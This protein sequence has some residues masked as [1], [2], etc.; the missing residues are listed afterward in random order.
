MKKALLIFFAIGCILVHLSLLAAD[1]PAETYKVGILPFKINAAQDL[2]YLQE[3]ILDMLTSRIAWENKILVIDKDLC[4]RAYEKYKGNIKEKNA[5]EI[6]R[7]LGA[8]YLLFGS[9]TIFGNSASLDAK[10]VD[11][12]GEK[13]TVTVYDQSQGMDGIIPKI[14][15]FATSIN[16]SIFGRVQP[17]LA[18]KPSVAQTPPQPQAPQR[19]VS[20]MNPEL[21]VPKEEL[22]RDFSIIEQEK[23]KRTVEGFLDT[24]EAKRGN[25][26]K[27]RNFPFQ[28]TGM[29]IGDVDNDGNNEIVFINEE[30]DL[31][32]YRYLKGA[33]VSVREIKG[34][35]YNQVVSVDVADINENGTE[36]IFISN[37]NK[38][39]VSSFVLEW[40]GKDFATIKDDLDW[41]LRVIKHPLTGP[42]LLGQKKSLDKPF[43]AGI[44]Q[45]V[46]R[47][48][49]YVEVDEV[50][51]ESSVSIYGFTAGDVNGDG[52]DEFVV[53]DEDDRLR[54]LAKGGVQEWKS[55]ENFGGCLTYVPGEKTGEETDW[56]SKVT[57]ENR[58]YLQPRILLCD[59]DKNKTLEVLVIQN[60][61]RVS[62][63]VQRYRHY[64]SGHIYSLSWDGLGLVENW[65]T[66]KISGYLPDFAVAD[67]DNDGENELV[68]PVVT[69]IGFTYLYKSRSAII[70]YD[71]KF[72][73]QESEAET[74]TERFSH[75][76]RRCSSGG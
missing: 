42:I 26:W 22:D 49:K 61:S 18:M 67:I 14:N 5:R 29:D 34:K 43:M 8:D 73:Q 27:S 1:Q 11:L 46:W 54:V 64:G 47:D 44:Y 9:I 36:E 71:L 19:P 31:W 24:G 39:T 48:G 12:K 76:G 6:G 7:E 38:G 25:F 41:Y 4:R 57:E 33:M 28:I 66:K 13:P 63:L 3:G 62:R 37:L 58:R 70:S 10:I 68:A 35:P 23:T 53:L 30:G 45:L 56:S 16:D 2:T 21:L 15:D 65:K 74:S 32:I 69:R 40:N 52:V 51:G 55:D 75:Q 17:R 50:T 20:E 59:L 72:K 60:K